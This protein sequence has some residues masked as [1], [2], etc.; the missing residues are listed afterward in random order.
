MFCI[1]KVCIENVLQ[2]KSFANKLF[3]MNSLHSNC[4]NQII[5]SEITGYRMTDSKTAMEPHPDWSWMLKYIL[6]APIS[7]VYN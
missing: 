2:T 5:F 4:C 1:Q 7:I 3:A 6:G